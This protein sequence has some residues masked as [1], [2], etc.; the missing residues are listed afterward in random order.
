MSE[1]IKN[2]VDLE[3]DKR[4][5]RRRWLRITL[6]VIG[7]IL[8]VLLL[9]AIIFVIWM[10]PI[11]ESY[12]ERNDKEL[13]GRRIEMNNLR[14]RLFSGT[15]SADNIIL[16]EADNTT[17]F[18]SIDRIEAELD[19]MDI[20]D[21]HIHVTR[22]HLTRPYLSVIQDGEVFNFDD[23]V[24]YLF[25]KYIVPGIVEEQY[26]TD[27]ADDEWKITIENVTVEDGHIEYIDREIEQRWNITAMN[28][29]TK[30]FVMADAMSSIDASL[31]IN[32]T[33]NVGGV[34]LFNYDTFD[35]DFQGT[36]DNFQLSDTY[37]YWTPYL[38]VTSV[39]GV[40]EAEAH[41][42]GN[43][44]NIFAMDISGSFIINDGEI[45]G[46]DGGNI[47]SAD[48]ISGD[49]ENLN[50]EYERYAFNRLH[51]MGYATQFIL[52][53]DGTTNF[54]GLFPEE[55]EVT[56]ETSAK[57]LGGEMYDIREEVRITTSEDDVITD[58]SITI[59]DLQLTNGNLH[60]A[61]HTLHK[62]FTYDISDLS[63]TAKQLDIDGT[64]DITINGNVPKQGKAVIRWEG[65]LDDFHN[66][67]I[68]AILSNV[69]IESLEPYIEY[70]TAFPVESGNLTFRSQNTI[71]NGELN[72]INQLGTYNFKLGKRDKSMEVDFNLPLR[73]G[74]YIL[75][76]KDDHID[77]ELP[78]SGN[79]DSPEFSYQRTIL[80]AIGN[81]LVKVVAAPFEW[82]SGDKQDAFRHI[83][84]DI[85]EPGLTAEQYARIDKMAEALAND[86]TLSVR[87][88]HEVNYK[89]ATQQIAELNLKIA[90]YNSQ[91]SDDKHR[92]DM[93]DFAKINNMRLSNKDVVDFTDSML[94]AQGIDP[95]QMTTHAKAR[96][97]YGDLIDDQLIRVMEHR[98]K[99]I[100]EY[101][102]FQHPELRAGALT[103]DS[104][105][106]DK[107]INSSGR[108]RYTV[109]LVID[110]EPIAIDAPDD[111]P[112]E[113]EG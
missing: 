49:I 26:G 30:N 53:A 14:L 74:I 91:Q 94:M 96:A 98:N 76:D 97:L 12:I 78:V 56:V 18:A 105:E 54:S 111:E 81:L 48:S 64:N 5:P 60:Y 110:G 89:R 80:K 22:A 1:S 106:R 39:E 40:G 65:S 42:V 61:D 20:M 66:Q 104:I 113:E 107:V 21:G 102:I 100:S 71:T 47:L 73:A 29:Y 99:T 68:M 28:L 67:S 84:V 8:L 2:Q 79:I 37:K 57:S 69:D 75:T 41:L 59:D 103:I 50:I 87:L 27:D 70:F 23:L 6:K 7:I 95:S 4:K 43:V 109:T 62:E 58:M 88:T 31:C 13:L 77:I 108:N 11:V 51:A 83:S 38:N 92:L 34:L 52:N 17:R 72:G 45:L 101:I 36:I 24:E 32:G 33:A 85:L 93:L 9:L 35:F 90:Y 112:S 25:V 86:E 55:T 19:V 63:V 10:G 46:P 82:M 16:Y 15:A 3:N 44:D